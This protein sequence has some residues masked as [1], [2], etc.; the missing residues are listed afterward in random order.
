MSVATKALFQGRGTRVLVLLERVLLASRNQWTALLSGFFEPVFF[1]IA[2][3]WGLGGQ[4][5]SVAG[6]D[7]HSVDYS[8][9]IAPALLAASAMNGAVQY[10]TFNIF[11]KLKHSR[12]YQ[13]FL[14][15]PL[16]PGEIVASEV[17]W[18]AVRGG[19]YAV[20]FLAVMYAIGATTSPWALLVIPAGVLTALGF[21][22]AGMAA[23]TFVRSPQDFDIIR[24]VLLG[25]FL[26]SATFYPL[27]VYPQPVRLLVEYTPL[28]QAT[29]MMRS[30]TTGSISWSLLGAVVY[31][32][33]LIV[34]GVTAATHRL[35]G[36]LLS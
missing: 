17:S 5:T 19:S 35:R 22:A 6:S 20:G 4:A 32:I 28:C 34:L 25:M 16:E 15:T 26:F 24:V 8:S 29:E 21:A 31:F 18:A 30:L 1:L 23:T 10:A 36:L 27:S 3:R 2:F 7:G 33:V 9:Y 12:L 11:F 14:A 13:A